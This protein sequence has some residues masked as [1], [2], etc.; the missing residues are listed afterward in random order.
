MRNKTRIIHR[1]IRFNYFIH[2]NLVSI[3]FR[4]LLTRNIWR[5]VTSKTSFN[6]SD[7][8]HLIASILAFHFCSRNKWISLTKALFNY[9]CY[10]DKTSTVQT[11]Q[12]QKILTESI[13][14]KV[15]FN[16]LPKLIHMFLLF[17]FFIPINNKR[18]N[19]NKTS[20]RY[21]SHFYLVFFQSNISHHCK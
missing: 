2:L 11:F 21:L 19:Y 17:V 12:H 15:C 9:L 20:F 3:I 18:I 6:Y 14:S 8:F 7:R 16:I 13:S 4:L 10:F 1:N 5:M